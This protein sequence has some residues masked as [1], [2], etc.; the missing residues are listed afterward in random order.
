MGFTTIRIRKRRYNNLVDAVAALLSSYDVARPPRDG[1]DIETLDAVEAFEEFDILRDFAVQLGLA[2]P[3]ARDGD[4]ESIEIEVH[5]HHLVAAVAAIPDL[6]AVADVP[7][8]ELL[9]AVEGLCYE[10]LV[11]RTAMPH[12]RQE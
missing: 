6:V 9:V 2:E 12:H 8:A 7:E 10:Y 4:D 5:V 11:A 3:V 1:F